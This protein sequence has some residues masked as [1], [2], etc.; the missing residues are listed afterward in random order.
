MIRRHHYHHETQS[1][2]YTNSKKKRRGIP[3][4]IEMNVK[5]QHEQINKEKKIENIFQTKYETKKNELR[6]YST[7][8]EVSPVR[9]HFG[10]NANASLFMAHVVRNITICHENGLWFNCESS[11]SIIFRL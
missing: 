6:T 1:I 2:V 10:S 9:H 3:I 5:E 8:C 4:R 7:R 11:V